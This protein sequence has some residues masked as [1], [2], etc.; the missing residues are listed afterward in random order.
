MFIRGISVICE[1]APYIWVTLLWSFKASLSSGLLKPILQINTVVVC[2]S[3]ADVLFLWSLFVS[4]VTISC[5][6]LWIC[7]R[8]TP[9]SLKMIGHLFFLPACPTNRRP[10]PTMTWDLWQKCQ[11]PGPKM[12][13]FRM[14]GNVISYRR[15]VRTIMGAVSNIFTFKGV[16]AIVVLKNR[17]LFTWDEDW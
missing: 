5:P 4:Q 17:C 8:T 11:Y 6:P 3:N 12:S 14:K 16:I 1:C 15:I 13:W 7:P 10:A 2:F 9:L